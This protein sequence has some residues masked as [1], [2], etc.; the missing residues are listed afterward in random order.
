MSGASSTGGPSPYLLKKQKKKQKK[1]RRMLSAV[2]G[3]IPA[4][5][6]HAHK[7]LERSAG[8][9]D[10]PPSHL[11]PDR[12][13]ETT[14]SARAA[15]PESGVGQKP[16]TGPA[17]SSCPFPPDAAPVDVLRWLLHPVE[18]QT[19]FSEYWERK[20]LHIARKKKRYYGGLFDSAEFD[21]MLRT[22]YVKFGVNLDLTSYRDG[23]R[24]THNLP[25]RAHSGT[26]WF[27]SLELH[28]RLV[29]GV[30]IVV[31]VLDCRFRP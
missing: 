3:S 12:P 9:A 31:C 4:G 29:Y 14:N 6:P 20:P 7:S 18:I 15:R 26:I 19:F 23:V 27:H 16:G 25:G 30:W 11:H 10:V 22:N 1:R 8:S 24:E 28:T 2:P 13:H 17:N 5:A 21:R